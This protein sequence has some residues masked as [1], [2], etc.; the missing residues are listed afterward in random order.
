MR[1]VVHAPIPW[2]R[3][4]MAAFCAVTCLASAATGAD[5]SNS[6]CPNDR[7][8]GGWVRLQRREQMRPFAPSGCDLVV[9]SFMTFDLVPNG[10]NIEQIKALIAAFVARVPNMT[11]QAREQALNS[12]LAWLAAG[13]R[14]AT[15][16]KYQVWSDGCHDIG[17]GFET[18][19][20]PGGRASGEITLGQETPTGFKPIE[21]AAQLGPVSAYGLTFNPMLPSL[22]IN[23]AG[24]G[25]GLPLLHGGA[26]FNAGDSQGSTFIVKSGGLA[27]LAFK[28]EPQRNCQPGDM[29]VFCN[30]PT[31]CFNPT[32]EAQRRLCYSNPVK[33]A[34][35]PFE[36][37]LEVPAYPPRS[38]AQE[39]IVSSR[40]SWK[41]C[42]GC[43]QAQPP[44]DFPQKPCPDTAKEDA[45]LATNRAKEAAATADLAILWKS[46]EDEMSKAQSH[47]RQFQT[48]MR[49]CKI[50]TALTD[51][52][53]GTLGLFSPAGE[54]EIAAEGVGEAEAIKKAAET[55]GEQIGDPGSTLLTVISKLLNNEDPTAKTI[56]SEFLR[57]YQ[58]AV[59]AAEK[60]ITFVNGSSAT[61]LEEQ[62]KDCAG[63]IVLSDENWKGANEYI[64][65][66]KAAMANVPATQVLVNDI[67]QL[68][69]ELPDLQYRDYAACV[70]RA[71]CLKQPESSC[72]KLK[73]AGNWPDVQ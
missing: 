37:S 2:T 71:R 10:P 33:F 27:A 56:P 31:V 43:G 35:L 9:N 21:P 53:S 47:L 41:V 58:E 57:T 6:S 30:L 55:L 39:G 24:R 14:S 11:P 17:G 23:T 68:D 51:L 67:R 36:G 34:A 38:P 20:A 4:L 29:F 65:D 12:K 5:S 3:A 8:L 61:Q 32:D 1:R 7:P 22:Q 70:R 60:F 73:P 63:T 69:T 52:L 26:C 46:Y 15:K 13:G 40:I 54:A 59:E 45:D 66:L 25:E 16:L 28:I 50:Q 72:A 49:S 62:M 44:P 18:C 48:T 42:C 64:E 19:N